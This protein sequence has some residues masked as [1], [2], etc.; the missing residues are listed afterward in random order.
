MQSR[1]SVEQEIFDA[2]RVLPADK[3]QE[4]LDFVEFLQQK[5]A[6]ARL[7][8]EPSLREIVRLPIPERHKILEKYVPAMAAD[9]ATDPALTEFSD[10]DMDDWNAD[11]IES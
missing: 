9:F 11:P 5:I 6:V 7:E 1:V 2:V 8:T 4:V 3:Q 10:L